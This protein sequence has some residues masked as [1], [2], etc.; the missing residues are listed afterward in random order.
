M[1]IKKLC[2]FYWYS[3]Y[4]IHTYDIVYKYI[5]HTRAKLLHSAFLP[6]AFHLPVNSHAFSLLHYII[7]MIFIKKKIDYFFSDTDVHIPNS[8]E[9]RG[10]YCNY[11]IN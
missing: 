6:S 8:L 5:V 4:I 7:P 10:V 3:S 9:K 11:G 1:H 2:D